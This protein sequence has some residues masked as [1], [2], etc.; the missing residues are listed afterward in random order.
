MIA[1]VYVGLD[2]LT[3]VNTSFDYSKV[4]I[5]KNNAI[6]N[7]K[8]YLEIIV[9]GTKG[10][11]IEGADIIIE[12]NGDP[13]YD[14]TSGDKK[15]DSNGSTGL[16]EVD[17]S[18]YKYNFPAN[19]S[20]LAST[21]AID[22][23][24]NS[25]EIPIFESDPDNIDM[26]KSHKE[27]FLLDNTPPEI[28]DVSGRGNVSQKLNTLD[29]ID[30]DSLAITF[31]ASEPGQ[32]IMIFDTDFD[33]DFNQSNDTVFSGNVSFGFQTIYWR[34]VSEGE[35]ITDGIYPLEIIII[36]EFENKILEPYTAMTIR[37]V[38]TDS[39]NDGYLD[40]NDDL[41]FE[42]TQWEDNDGDGFGENPMGVEADLFPQDPTQWF[43][44]DRDG[45]GDNLEGNNPDMYPFDYTQWIDSDG[46]GYGDNVSGNN[47]DVFP[48]DPTQWLDSDEDG[49]GDNQSGNNPDV[50]PDNLYEWKDS[51]SDGYGDNR[52]DAFPDDPNEWEDSDSDGM[53]DNSDFLPSIN[54]FLFFFIIG[55]TV[56]IVLAGLYVFKGQK[57]AERP[58]ETGERAIP[59]AAAAPPVIEPVKSRP[60]PPKRA[61]KTAPKKTQKPQAPKKK[62]PPKKKA[63]SK[64]PP[65]KEEPPPPP[66]PP[67]DA[68]ASEEPEEMPPPPPKEKEEEE[69][70]E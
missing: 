39:D 70:E 57:R 40:V 69:K 63:P 37:I 19:Y 12:D 31:S 45:Y 7:V 22:V 2:S 16:I 53:G 41:P 54:N 13:I 47:S 14:S 29:R 59:Q 8:N 68:S 9:K 4:I 33:N 15:T 55:L 30:D 61:K 1:D 43:D 42:P 35:L 49:W 26:S 20:M 34:G 27:L 64:K 44:S 52:A 58:F 5:A 60:P 28:S 17:Y 32:F 24:Y 65:K 38:N 10:N 23:F 25:F 66:P 11:I 18:I 50:F 48:D 46:D 56:V 67:E 6:L 62:E 36:D 51:D 3:L 21:I